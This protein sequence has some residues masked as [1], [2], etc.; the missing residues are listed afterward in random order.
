[1]GGYLIPGIFKA[2]IFNMWGKNKMDYNCEPVEIKRIDIFW[3]RGLIQFRVVV[4]DRVPNVPEAVC[5]YK[6]QVSINFFKWCFH[7]VVRSAHTPYMRINDE[8]DGDLFNY[9][10]QQAVAKENK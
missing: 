9:E 8:E 3:L 4:E 1:M 6:T 10:R 7:V 5:K 2:P